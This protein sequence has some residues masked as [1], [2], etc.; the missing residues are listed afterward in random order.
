MVAL[1]S[2]F[3]AICEEPETVAERLLPT[4]VKVKKLLKLLSKNSP[5]R[6]IESC[7][8]S[9]STATCLGVIG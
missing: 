3:S 1:R 6:T 2:P 9:L 7:L 8:V 4:R 5:I